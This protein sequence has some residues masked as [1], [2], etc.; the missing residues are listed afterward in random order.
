MLISISGCSSCGKTTVLNK[1]SELNNNK[2]Q[3]SHHQYARELLASK[4]WTVVDNLN[5]LGNL[6]EFQDELLTYK[7]EQENKLYNDNI[8]YF[9]VERSFIDLYIYYR[10]QVEKILNI[11]FNYYNEPDFLKEY[12]NKCIHLTNTY[13]HSS[14]YLSQIPYLEHDNVRIIDKTFIDK[15]QQLFN[16]FFTTQLYNHVLIINS[17]S[18]DERCDLIIKNLSYHIN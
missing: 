7:L 16:Y 9:L 18:L 8:T 1:L 15:Q 12:K 4:N 10:L 11:D 5:T 17:T 6:C 2:L 13:Y 14:L 3:V